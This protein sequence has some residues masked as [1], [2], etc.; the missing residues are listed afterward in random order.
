VTIA[1][2]VLIAAVAATAPAAPPL[3]CPTGSRP[4]GAAPPQGSEWKC[5]DADGAATGPWLTWYG[6]G[7]LM[8]ERR[9]KQGKEHGRQRSWWP[10]GQLMM[11]GISVEGHRYKGFHYWSITGAPAALD[12]HTETITPPA[13]AAAP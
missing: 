11:E 6:N 8:S 12:V 10:N 2:L 5:V 9:M 4:E 1:S 7:Q 3:T 13:P